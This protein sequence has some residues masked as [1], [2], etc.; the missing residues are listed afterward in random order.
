MKIKYEVQLWFDGEQAVTKCPNG[1]TAKVGS[2]GCSKCMHFVNDDKDTKIVTC[3][4]DKEM[5]E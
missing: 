2:H 5:T 4:Y 3:S 1:A